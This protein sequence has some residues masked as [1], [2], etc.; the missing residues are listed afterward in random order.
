MDQC[1]LNAHSAKLASN[2]FESSLQCE[3]AFISPKS[4][5]KWGLQGESG[6]TS[7]SSLRRD[8]VSNAYSLIKCFETKDLL[9]K[10]TEFLNNCLAREIV[11]PVYFS[12]SLFVIFAICSSTMLTNCSTQV[13]MNNSF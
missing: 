2:Q 12:V 8:T 7:L 13:T 5:A 6:V 4:K 3:H 10:L 11:S 1:G 9:P